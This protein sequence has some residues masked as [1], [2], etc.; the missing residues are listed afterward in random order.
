[1]AGRLS[2][3]AVL[4]FAC[5]G[6]AACTGNPGAANLVPQARQALDVGGSGQP[7]RTIQALNGPATQAAT[8]DAGGGVGPGNRNLAGYV[9][10]S[11]GSTR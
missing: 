6:L 2:A 8:D 9:G 1:M 11:G 10:S 3:I 7:G 5:C 4:V